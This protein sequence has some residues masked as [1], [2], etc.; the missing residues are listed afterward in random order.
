MRCRKASGSPVRRR[1]LPNGRTIDS[2]GKY[3][4]GFAID[5]TNHRRSML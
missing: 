4:P 5:G 1:P 2:K 3:L